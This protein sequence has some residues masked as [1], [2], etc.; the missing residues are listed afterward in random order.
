MAPKGTWGYSQ[1]LDDVRLNTGMPLATI[2]RSTDIRIPVKTIPN[3]LIW[4]WI[5]NCIHGR[6]VP[7]IEMIN[8][9]YPKAG[10]TPTT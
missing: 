9:L 5:H 8:E 4:N 7:L 2:I 10:S 6:E 1:E 3:P